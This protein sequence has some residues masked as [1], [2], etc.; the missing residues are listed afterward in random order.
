VPVAAS[1]PAQSLTIE[2]I[3]I[4]DTILEALNEQAGVDYFE[5]KL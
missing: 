2:R 5:T 4:E 1:Y 3:H